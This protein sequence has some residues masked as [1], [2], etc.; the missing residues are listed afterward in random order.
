MW[1]KI[2]TNILSIW[3]SIFGVFFSPSL[4]YDQW[5]EF[6]NLN[7]RYVCRCACACLHT[8]MVSRAFSVKT[9]EHWARLQLSPAL[10]FC[11]LPK[12]HLITDSCQSFFI[13]PVPLAS[14]HVSNDEIDSP[15]YLHL[16]VS[17]IHFT[18]GTFAVSF[19]RSHSPAVSLT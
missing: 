19:Q 14:E 15:L 4:V 9:R 3:T 1:R 12:W 17:V 16:A 11:T 10:G 13:M 2:R 18:S 8:D 5:L 6:N 7:G